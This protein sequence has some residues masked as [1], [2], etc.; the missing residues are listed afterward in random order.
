MPTTPSLEAISL[1]DLTSVTGGCGGKKKCCC[2]P[3]APPQPAPV[4]AAPQL[5]PSDN[6]SVSVNVGQ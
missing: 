2:P 6:V 5:P 1:V 3:P 4:Q